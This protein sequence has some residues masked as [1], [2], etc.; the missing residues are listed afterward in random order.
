MPSLTASASGTV[1]MVV[2]WELLRRRNGIP[3]NR[4]EIY[5]QYNQEQAIK[6]LQHESGEASVLRESLWHIPSQNP[7]EVRGAYLNFLLTAKD[8]SDHLLSKEK[9]WDG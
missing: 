1:R 5:D 8:Q 7:S 9:L 2:D 3:P 4:K 6:S